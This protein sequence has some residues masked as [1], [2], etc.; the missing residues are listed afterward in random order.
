M[1]PSGKFHV[2]MTHKK[3]NSLVFRCDKL[4]LFRLI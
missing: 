1:I 3:E 2:Y 4:D